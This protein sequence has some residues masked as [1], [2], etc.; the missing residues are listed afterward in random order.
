MA[1]LTAWKF[2]TPTGADAVLL[3]LKQLEDQS[4]S[5]PIC[6]TSRRPTS[7]TPSAWMIERTVDSAE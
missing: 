4:S 6:P 2:D 5:A 3:K 1:T 7:A